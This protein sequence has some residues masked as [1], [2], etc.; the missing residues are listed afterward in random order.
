MSSKYWKVGNLGDD[1]PKIIKE[2]IEIAGKLLETNQIAQLLLFYNID[3]TSIQDVAI[4]F[5]NADME[6]DQMKLSSDAYGKFDP[7]EN[8]HVLNLSSELVALCKDLKPGMDGYNRYKIEI[9]FIKRI[10]HYLY[11]C[12]KR[13]IILCI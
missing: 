11:A 8:E 5:D 6:V 4:E 3:G 2:A 13:M 10:F 12:I 9:R 1:V 7:F